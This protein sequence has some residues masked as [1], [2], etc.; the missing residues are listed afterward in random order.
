MTS[1]LVGQHSKRRHWAL[2]FLPLDEGLQE[3][4]SPYSGALLPMYTYL[5]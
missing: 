5:I 4:M 1:V 2:A 3:Q